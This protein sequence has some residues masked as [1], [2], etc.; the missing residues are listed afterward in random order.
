MT[1][2]SVLANATTVEPRAEIQ[3]ALAEAGRL[4]PGE[5]T[6]ILRAADGS[7]QVLPEELVRILS[8]SAHEL[9]AGHAVTLLASE[10]HLTPAETAELL[11]L[12]RPFVVRLLDSGDIASSHLPGSRHRIVRLADALAFQERRTRRREGRLRIAE[13][14]DEAGLPY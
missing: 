10:V 3:D 7:E 4:V 12:S 1:R 2:T 14:A 8:A 6:V 11:G 13:A 9:A 5:V